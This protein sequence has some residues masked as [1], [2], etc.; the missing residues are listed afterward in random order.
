[1]RRFLLVPTQPFSAILSIFVVLAGFALPTPAAAELVISPLRQVI[2]AGTPTA[3]YEISN[4][5]SR[6]LVTNIS[7]IDLKAEEFGYSD[8][9]P[10]L[11]EKLS[12]APYLIV[13]PTF[14]RLEPG[15]RETIKVALRGGAKIPDGERRSHLLIEASAS[16][17][18]LR[19]AS[20]GVQLD[21]DVAIS[22]PVI[23]RSGSASV[24]PRIKKA[25]LLR[26]EDGTLDL[27]A[28]I[29]AN[30]DFSAYGF[31]AA[32]FASEKGGPEREIAR[33]EN[34]AA[35][36]DA[37]LRKVI[38]PLRTKELD[39]GVLTIRYI[40]SAEFTGIR[41][42]ERAFEVGPPSP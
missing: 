7:W 15:A 12:A 14:L 22:T 10:K 13:A 33:I 32:Y 34:V 2:T 27:E 6:T 5:S 17:T 30:G 18:L 28:K 24:K 9:P 35:Y 25:R 38:L 26:N 31:L 42:S 23:L 3:I 41:F 29:E 37:K 4:P 40:G 11:R 1:M 16:R 8:A 39:P 36:R 21:L 19:K 20:T